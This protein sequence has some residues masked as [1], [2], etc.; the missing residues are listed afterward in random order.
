MSLAC[1]SEDS[2][3]LLCTCGLG[4]TPR[5]LLRFFDPAASHCLVQIGVRLEEL[6]L[7][8]DVR[9]LGI[10]QRLLGGGNLQVDGRA[11]SSR[12]CPNFVRSISA[13]STSWNALMIDFSYV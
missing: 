13:F 12:I 4:R 11:F 5:E 1:S 10:E 7:R 6:R 2:H 9:Q 8:S 3:Y